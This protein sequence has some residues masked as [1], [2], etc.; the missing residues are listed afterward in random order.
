MSI[1]GRKLSIAGTAPGALVLAVATLLCY[2]VWHGV[3]E[4]RLS[5]ELIAQKGTSFVLTASQ[6]SVLGAMKQAFAD[7]RYRGMDLDEAA[8]LA[9]LVPDWHPT[10][11]FLLH[12]WG[13]PL[14]GGSG[15]GGTEPYIA[16]FHIVLV[17]LDDRKTL[18]TVKTVYSKVLAGKRPSLHNLGYAN[19][20]R[21]VSPRPEEEWQ[22]IVAVAAE[23]G[24]KVPI[25]TG[26]QQR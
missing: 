23:M 8:S 7:R 16:Y 22:V 12:N 20:Y 17:P 10:N 6:S 15:Y 5:H 14:K 24:L 21:K 1:R 11:G 19:R 3:R 2:A 9:G 13:L 4:Q 26:Q 18:I 25:P